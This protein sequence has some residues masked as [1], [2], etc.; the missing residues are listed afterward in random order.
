MT[1][2]QEANPEAAELHAVALRGLYWEKMMAKGSNIYRFDNSHADALS[3]VD[4]IVKRAEID[5]VARV[6]AGVQGSLPRRGA[7]TLPQRTGTPERHPD[8]AQAANLNIA[9][10]TPDLDVRA[11]D[12]LIL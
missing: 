8:R 11:G 3:I 7:N 9:Q 2:W 5:V 10:Q 4:V 12:I 6:L 1:K